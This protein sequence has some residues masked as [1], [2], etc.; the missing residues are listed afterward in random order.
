MAIHGVILC[1][2]GATSS[3]LAK[4]VTDEAKKQGLDVTVDAGGTGEFKKK[5]EEYDVALLEPQVRHLKKE[6]E[7]I[8]EKFGIPVDIVDM[9]AFALMDAKKILNQ[10]IELAKKNGKDA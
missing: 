2:W 7:T 3:A 4:K 10:I 6:V 5:A 8:A 9:Q 1:S